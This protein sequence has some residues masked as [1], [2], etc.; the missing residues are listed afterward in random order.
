MTA[1]LAMRFAH[2]VP[3]VILPEAACEH[4]CMVRTHTEKQGGERAEDRWQ[5]VRA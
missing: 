1:Q 3:A 2:A 4:H 5:S